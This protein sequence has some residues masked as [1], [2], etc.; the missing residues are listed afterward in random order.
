MYPEARRVFGLRGEATP[1]Q[2]MLAQDI[3]RVLNLEMPSELT[4]QAVSDFIAS[5]IRKY[6]RVKVD[7]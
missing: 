7:S 6:R 5:N 2:I 4:K 3:S 1:A